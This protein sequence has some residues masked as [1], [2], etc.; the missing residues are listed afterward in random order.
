MAEPGCYAFNVFPIRG[1]HFFYQSGCYSP[2]VGFLEAL[3][4]KLNQF[5]EVAII[6][7]FHRPDILL[8]NLVTL[9]HE[10][11]LWP[12]SNGKLT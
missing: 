11:G 12:L 8:A 7:G 9:G 2:L 10:V 6:S 1:A 3:F 4:K 5:G